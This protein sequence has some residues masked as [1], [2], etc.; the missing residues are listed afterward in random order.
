MPSSKLEDAFRAVGNDP[1]AVNSLELDEDELME[2]GKMLNPYAKVLGPGVGDKKHTKSI[3]T[4]FTNM[5]EDYYM[6]YITT[7]MVGFLF[8]MQDEKSPT[9]DVRRYTPKSAKSKAK[10][11]WILRG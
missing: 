5:R 11:D 3:A 4:T 8:R 7:A 6:R 10:G 2:L 1:E 9:E